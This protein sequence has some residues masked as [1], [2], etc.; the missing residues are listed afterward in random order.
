MASAEEC[1]V[2]STSGSTTPGSGGPTAPGMTPSVP[3]T[4]PPGGVPNY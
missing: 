3:G 4:V 1:A 2:P